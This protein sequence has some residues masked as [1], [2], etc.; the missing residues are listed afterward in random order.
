M[1]AIWSSRRQLTRKRQLWLRAMD[2][3]QAQLAYTEGPMCR[4]IGFFAQGKLKKFLSAAVQ[5]NRCATPPTVA[6]IVDL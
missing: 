2:A 5:L 3:L 6:R 4:Y 1:A